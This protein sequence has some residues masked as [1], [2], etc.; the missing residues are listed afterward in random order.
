MPIF[1]IGDV[2][3]QLDKLIALLRGAGLAD[4]KLSW[5]GRD[6]TLWFIG[7]FV[8]RGPEG[9]GVIDLVMR[10]QREAPRARGFVGALLGNHDP[11][12]LSA[13]HF[14]DTP[15][16]GPHGTF[17]HDWEVNGGNAADLER[18]TEAHVEWL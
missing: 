11:L 12:L 3:G 4:A 9:I 2:H 16:S 8:D 14:S 17:K 10:L 6:A 5:A 18:L 1:V 13:Y 7:D 15:I